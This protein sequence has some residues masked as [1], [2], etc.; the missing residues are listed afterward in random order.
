VIFYSLHDQCSLGRMT[1]QWKIID[2]LSDSP[3]VAAT[4]ACTRQLRKDFDTPDA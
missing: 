2:L 3:V 1:K 4:S